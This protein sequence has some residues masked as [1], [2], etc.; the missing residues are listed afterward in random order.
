MHY[1][2]MHRTLMAAAA[3]IAAHRSIAAQAARPDSVSAPIHDVR[4]DVAFGAGRRT[5]RREREHDVRDG[6]NGAGAA[7]ASGLDPGRL[8]AREFCPLGHGLRGDRRE[9]Q[10]ARL[11]QARLR[12]VAHPPGGR[13][14]GA[15]AVHLQRGLAR[16]R[17]TWAKPDF[18]LF[19]G[20]NLFLYPEGQLARLSEHGDGAHRA[21]VARHHRARRAAEPRTYSAT[22]YHDLVDMPFFVGRYDLDSARISNKWVRYAT[23]PAGVVAGT[24]RASAWEQLKRVIPAESRSIRRSAVDNY[25]VMQIVDSSFGGASGLEHQNSHVDVLAPSYVGSEFQPS[26]YAHEIFHSWNVKRLRPADMWPYQY[27]HP[28]PTP[29]LWVS[30]G[31]TD[32]YAD[33]AEVRGGVVNDRASTR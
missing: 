26:L 15:R 28:Q 9:R 19:N 13:E 30:E 11:G 31:I 4:Y 8:R 29:W 14:D 6:G 3:C 17:E 32:Y 7:V 1:R 33:L 27:S 12:H 2:T 25:T 24:A 10:A 16:Q 21:G 5:S 22:N 23:Y 18:L 20:T